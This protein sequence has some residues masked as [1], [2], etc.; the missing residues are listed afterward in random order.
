MLTNLL[1]KYVLNLKSVRIRQKNEACTGPQNYG[2]AALLL[3]S[4]SPIRD[5]GSGAFLTPRSGIG[6]PGW[7]K[8]LNPDSGS[9]SGM[10]IPD[11]I[12]E[13]LETIFWIKNTSIL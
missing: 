1:L 7:V 12:S 6:D 2:F 10:N 8:N 3:Q 4:V 13:S 11:Y 5:L 9:G